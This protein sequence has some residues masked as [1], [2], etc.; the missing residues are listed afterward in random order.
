LNR[1][2]QTTHDNVNIVRTKD[3]IIVGEW[4]AGSEYTD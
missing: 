3:E 2:L 1:N 4:S